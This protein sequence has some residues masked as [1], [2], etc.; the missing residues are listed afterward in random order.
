MYRSKV[1]AAAVAT[2]AGLAV[3]MLGPPAGASVTLPAGGPNTP[4]ATSGPVGLAPAPA[5]APAG[6]Q[7]VSSTPGTGLAGAG[8]IDDHAVSGRPVGGATTDQIVCCA[9]DDRTR[10]N[11][12][13][14]FPVNA[15]VQLVR[16]DGTTTWGCSG[17]LYGPSIVATAGHCVHPGAG[18]DGGGDSGFYPPEDFE[19]IPGRNFPSRPYGTCHATQLMSVTGWTQDGSRD[20][21][22]GAVRLDCTAGSTTGTWGFWWQGATLTGTA[23]TVSGYPCDQTFGTQWRHAGRSVLTT[24]TRRIFYDNDTAG[25]QSGSPVYQ[26]RASGSA[27]C[28]GWCVMGIHTTGGTSSNGGTRI[29]EPVYNNLLAWRG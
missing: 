15:I 12:T 8:E 14:T 21:D 9:P 4:V 1:L 13:T 22:Y 20:F 27:F 24:T 5:P 2:V 3:S 7:G 28:V 29:T 11:P 6:Q 10:V 18:A 16:D 19:I 26:N 17:W 25:C 23:S